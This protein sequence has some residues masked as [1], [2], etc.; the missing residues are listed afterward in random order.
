MGSQAF[1]SKKIELAGT[2][3]S[4][5]LWRNDAA[6]VRLLHDLVTFEFAG[7]IGHQTPIG[8]G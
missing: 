3:V 7:T 8:N 5:A 1:F 6:E 4:P 2:R